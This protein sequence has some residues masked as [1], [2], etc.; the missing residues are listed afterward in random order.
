[1]LCLAHWEN[2]GLPSGAPPDLLQPKII[3]DKLGR[4]RTLYKYRA[5]SQVNNH[6]S[7]WV[8]ASRQNYLWAVDHGLELCRQYERRYQHNLRKRGAVCHAARPYIEWFGSNIPKIPDIGLLEFRQAVAR[9]PFDCYRV[10]D[11]VTAYREYYVRYKQHLAKWR[12]GDVPEW[13][14]DMTNSLHTNDS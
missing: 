8:R 2:G 9:D 13:F 5:T 14:V 3:T 4:I 11:P 7:K 12:L 6:V 1:M 10:G